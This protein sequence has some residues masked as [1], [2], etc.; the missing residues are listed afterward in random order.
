MKTVLVAI[1]DKKAKD[2]GPV[3]TAKN[4][5]V[6]T[7]DFTTACSENPNYKTYPEDY[8]ICAIAEYESE[9]A[10]ITPFKEPKILAE[11]ENFVI[12]AEREKGPCLEDTK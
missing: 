4:P 1:Y 12:K 3:Y 10:K 2:F 5:A 7:R 6:A 11:A 9:T 8:C